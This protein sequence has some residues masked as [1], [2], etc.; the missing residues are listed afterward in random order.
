[1]RFIG[2]TL[3]S[4]L[5]GAFAVSCGDGEEKEPLTLAAYVQTFV[6]LDQTHEG[7]AAPLRQQLDAEFGG[8]PESAVVPAEVINSFR[9]LADEDARFTA[10]IADL[11]APPEATEVHDEAVSAL[12]ADSAAVQDALD[13]VSETTTVAEF[14]AL[15]TTQDV[16]DAGQ[17]RR[18]ACVAVQEFANEQGVSVDLGC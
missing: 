9:Q 1:V 4:I 11:D 10:E 14:N 15:L 2:L 6:S 7:R 5:L 3:A 16:V 8:L 17:R 13:Q 18:E 12:E